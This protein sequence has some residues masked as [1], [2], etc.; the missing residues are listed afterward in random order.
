ML[1]DL[2]FV[3]LTWEVR[4][5]NYINADKVHVLEYGLSF[6]SRKLR[7]TSGNARIE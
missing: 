7:E 6:L 3:M 1:S 4:G 5:L 2:V